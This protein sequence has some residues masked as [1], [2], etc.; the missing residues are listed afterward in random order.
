MSFSR[1]IQRQM[2]EYISRQNNNIIGSICD[3]QS[4]PKEQSKECSHELSDDDQYDND[5]FL[6]YVPLVSL[7]TF[8]TFDTFNLSCSSYSFVCSSS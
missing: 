1:A 8:S 7:A 6:D 5:V 2:K 4:T 3:R